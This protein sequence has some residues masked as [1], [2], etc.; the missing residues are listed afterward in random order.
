M[1]TVDV[2]I[3][4]YNEEDCL[5]EL[6][7]RL[8][9]VMDGSPGYAWRVLLVENGSTDSSSAVIQGIAASDP[10]FV[11]VPL[12]RNFGTE[13]GI[14]AGLAVTR[15]DAAVTMQADLEDPPELIPT[16]LQE[17]EK[18]AYYVYASVASRER[19]PLWRRLMTASYYRVASWA[20]NGSIVKNASDFRLLDRHLYTILNDIQEQN[21]FLRG[22]VTWA[23]FPSAAVP[24][25]R[26]E[27]YAGESKF[28]LSSAA[29]FASLGILSQSTK[30][31][32]FITGVGLVLSSL[33][34]LALA[35]LTIRAFT[36]GVPFAGFG[37]I[38]GLQIL[39]FGLTMVFLGLVSEYIALIY[40][41]V[42][43]RPHFILKPRE[44]DSA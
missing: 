42:R 15:A 4:V 28:K 16:M 13:G 30:P 24:F 19:Q 36:A 29:F 14:L 20:S 34:L 6:A 10:R 3:P 22:L 12:V 5:P 9:A 1:R 23:G 33:S 39:F 41:E 31:L 2:V 43:P 11:E 25:S 18:G 26:G 40:R 37:T 17:W 44:D 38:V 35:V 21:L 27:R 8:A 32:R 7:R